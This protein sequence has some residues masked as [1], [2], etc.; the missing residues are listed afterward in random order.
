MKLANFNEAIKP[1]F[2]KLNLKV[3]DFVY[4]KDTNCLIS[5]DS[6]MDQENPED[7]NEHYIVVR[8]QD[9]AILSGVSDGINF[10]EE[11]TLGYITVKNDVWKLKSIA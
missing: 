2:D 10:Y 6:Y 8:C 9:G 5:N 1:V 7:L 11:K 3:F 4:D